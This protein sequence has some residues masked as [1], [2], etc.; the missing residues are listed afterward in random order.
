MSPQAQG[1]L[2]ATQAGMPPND[3]TKMSPNDVL[4][5]ADQYAQQAQQAGPQ[6][7]QALNQ[8]RK[9]LPENI[10]AAVK[11]RLRQM[12]Q[13]MEQQGKQMLLQGGGAPM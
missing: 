2:G 9:E 13:S 10:Y 11:E 6:R 4:S 5:M 12:D 7:R 8:M 1:M 3:F